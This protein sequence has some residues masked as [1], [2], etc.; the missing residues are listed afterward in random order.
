MQKYDKYYSGN[1]FD[2]VSELG[3]C[4]DQ[5]AQTNKQNKIKNERRN[6]QAKRQ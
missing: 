6:E 4:T 5:K 1:K 3:V 2:S